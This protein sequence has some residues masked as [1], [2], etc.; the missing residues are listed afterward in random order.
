[1]TCD[2][3]QRKARQPGPP[4][5]GPPLLTAPRP[6][7]CVHPP[8]ASIPSLNPTSGQC[9]T[10][11]QFPLLAL[12]H[13]HLLYFSHSLCSKWPAQVPPSRGLAAGQRSLW[14][15]FP[16]DPLCP[17]KQDSQNVRKD[18]AHVV[19]NWDE[20]STQGRWQT[21]TLSSGAGPAAWDDSAN[22]LE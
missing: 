14:P 20:L 21:S 9:S 18:T 6:G 11:K 13:V 8:S 1:M 16:A 7:L 10:L 4:H 2:Q 22:T 15:G 19:Q 12:F 5:P 3:Y 17:H